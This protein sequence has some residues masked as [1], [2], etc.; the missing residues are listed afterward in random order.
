MTTLHP[1]SNFLFRATLDQTATNWTVLSL[2]T[3]YGLGAF[4]EPALAVPAAWVGSQ[5]LLQVVQNAEDG[6][7]YQVSIQFSA[8]DEV[9]C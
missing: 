4:C 2:I 6:V 1:Q 7:H 9:V 5:G 8:V 3:E